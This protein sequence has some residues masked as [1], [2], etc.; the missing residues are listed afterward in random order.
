MSASE[1]RIYFLIQRVAHRLKTEADASL[2]ESCGLTTSQAAALTVI[3]QSGPTNHKHVADALAQRESAIT[4][5]AVRL[6]NAGY[7]TRE[8]SPADGRAWEL[9]V[10]DAGRAALAQA[11]ASFERI[12]EILDA[13]FTTGQMESLANRLTQ[14]LDTL[15]RS[16]QQFTT[17]ERNP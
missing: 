13:S 12:N 17:G 2:T 4:T 9:D 6:L 3:A 14:V 10:T 16:D 15:Q 7:I 1:H 11:S 5:M 8:I